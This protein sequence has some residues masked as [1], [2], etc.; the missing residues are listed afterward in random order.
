MSLELSYKE[1]CMAAKNKEQCQAEPKKR[2]D[3]DRSQSG[4]KKQGDV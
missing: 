2:H 1:L 3:Y 4:F